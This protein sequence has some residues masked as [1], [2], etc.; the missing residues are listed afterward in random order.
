[1]YETPTVQEV[2]PAIS[3]HQVA[4]LRR[5][6]PYEQ[7]EH[8]VLAV[9]QQLGWVE[10]NREFLANHRA[11]GV[12]EMR[13]LMALLGLDSVTTRQQAAGLLRLA[14]NVFMPPETFRGAVLPLPDGRVRVVVGLCPMFEKI[15]RQG[16]RGVTAC[17]SWHHRR[18]WFDAMGVDADDS[19]QAEQNWGEP[20]CVTEITFRLPD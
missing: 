9:A 6:Y 1:M 2:V 13:A 12:E 7:D 4:D 18:G 5:S 16:A 11:R 19:V 20:A 8:W 14:Y 17:G 10:A 3:S 15:G